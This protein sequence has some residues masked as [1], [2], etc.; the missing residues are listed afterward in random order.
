[1]TK[2]KKDRQHKRIMDA[3][4]DL[5]ETQDAL[6]IMKQEEKLKRYFGKKKFKKYKKQM[7][8][9]MQYYPKK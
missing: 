7:F 2:L 3:G 1:M 4:Q 5:S 6:E 8:P 9:D